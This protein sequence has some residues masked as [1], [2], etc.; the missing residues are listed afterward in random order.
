MIH[1]PDLGNTGKLIQSIKALMIECGRVALLRMQEGINV[2]YKEDNSPVTNADIEISTLIFNNLKSLTPDIPVIC[3]ERDLITPL[4]DDYF[5]L[6]DPIDGTRSYIRGEDTFTVNIALIKHNLAVLGFIYQP[7][8]KKLYYTDHNNNLQIEQN[9]KTVNIENSLIK[10]HY[11]AV[12]GSRYSDSHTKDFLKSHLITKIV[13]IPS[14]IKF[15]LIAEGT[16][17]VYPG[18]GTTMEWDVAA[19]HALVKAAGG[20]IVDLHGNELSYRKDGF[21]NPH[22]CAYS[23]YWCKEMVSKN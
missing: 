10:D 3:E 5:W 15:C 8:T 14:S 13:S 12:V 23:K 18:F 21:Q 4:G 16:A 6:V 19:G 22:F 17:D 11:S 9:G 20:N 2:F 1:L 7:F